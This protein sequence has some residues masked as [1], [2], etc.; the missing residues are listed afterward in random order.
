MSQTKIMPNHYLISS[1]VFFAG[2]SNAESR[3]KFHY[4]SQVCYTSFLKLNKEKERRFQ[5]KSKDLY[6]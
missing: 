2:K 3:V 1:A 4:K 5:T 6:N